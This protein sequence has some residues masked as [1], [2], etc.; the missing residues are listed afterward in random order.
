VII[1]Q[2]FEAS[3]VLA[4]LKRDPTITLFFGVPTMYI[5]LGSV[6]K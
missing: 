1:R 6:K 2:K 5:R 4:A 3:D